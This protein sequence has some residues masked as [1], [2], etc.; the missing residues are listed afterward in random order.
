MEWPSLARVAVQGLWGLLGT[1]CDFYD[2]HFSD[3]QFYDSHFYDSYF[4]DSHFYDPHFDDSHCYN[5]HFYDSDFYD[6]LEFHGSLRFWRS[7]VE[8]LAD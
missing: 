4:C 1:W 3:S 2:S 6:S 5:P 8:V 7:E